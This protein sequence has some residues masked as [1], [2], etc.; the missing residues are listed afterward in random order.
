M[1]YYMSLYIIICHNIWILIKI[2]ILIGLSRGRGI[3]VLNNLI[4]ITDHLKQK[5]STWVIQKYIENPL[6]IRKRKFDIR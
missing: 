6:V 2:I 1:Y 4:E 5:E 3:T